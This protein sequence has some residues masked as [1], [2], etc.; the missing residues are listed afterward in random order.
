MVARAAGREV[1]D[2]SEQAQPVVEWARTL[3]E[4]KS[5]REALGVLG[6]W[7]KDHPDDVAALEV[8]GAA[9]AG[10]HDWEAAEAL[11]RRV[12]E[13]SPGSARAWSN[14]GVGLR[15][16]GRL[17]EARE[18][19]RHALDLEPDHARARIELGKLNAATPP[20]P[21]ASQPAGEAQAAPQLHAVGTGQ[22]GEADAALG[23]QTSG[24]AAPSRRMTNTEIAWRVIG[25][26]LAVVAAS[27]LLG[28]A[29]TAFV[30][31]HGTPPARPGQI[32]VSPA[33]AVPSTPTASPASES[34]PTPAASAT[35]YDRGIDLYRAGKY[36]EAIREFEAA[37]SEGH[38]GAETWIEYCREVLQQREQT[39][40]AEDEIAKRRARTEQQGGFPV[41]TTYPA[42]P[43]PKPA[44]ELENYGWSRGDYGTRYLVGTVVNNSSREF[45]YVQVEF[46]LY[47]R[48]GR[49]VGSTFANV[50]NLEP[51]GQ[52][53]FK[54]LVMQD[55]AKKAEPK[56]VTGF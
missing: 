25:L 32:G 49:Q 42:V 31:P 7:L 1:V 22:S 38:A 44:L 24:T 19:Q 52:W 13:A 56:G 21:P 20:S 18:A 9:H 16:L 10:L 6:P 48:S 2:V 39:K 5:Y 14:W 23:G 43:P 33:Q 46:N 26:L 45:G 50:N 3:V 37:R 53:R 27:L 11:A 51:G 29:R 30:A 8:L 55:E 40:A 34:L 17:D 36:E 15:K 12:V 35:P 41:I 47:D 4:R 28:L 54:A